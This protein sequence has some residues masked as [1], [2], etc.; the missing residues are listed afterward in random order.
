MV[1]RGASNGLKRGA[2]KVLK[3]ASQGQIRGQEVG[4][5]G[6]GGGQGPWWRMAGEGRLN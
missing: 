3:G 6:P 5:E 2:G 1:R 4:R